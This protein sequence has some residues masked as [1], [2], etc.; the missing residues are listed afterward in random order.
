MKQSTSISTILALSIIIINVAI[1]PVHALAIKKDVFSPKDSKNEFLLNYG[2]NR[3]LDGVGVDF[4]N[5]KTLSI[6]NINKRNLSG[7][8]KKLGTDLL[9]LI[10]NDF[11]LVNQNR[12]QV[13]SQMKELK[14]FIAKE[15]SVKIL[16]RKIAD[17]K[18]NDLVYVYIKLKQEFQTFTIDPIVWKVTDRDEKNHLAVALVE[19]D[20]LEALA[21]LNSVK[22][23][24]SVVQPIVNSGSVVTEGD[25][26]HQTD[27]VRSNYSQSGAGIKVGVISDGVDNIALSQSSG[28]LPLGVNVLN[29][30]V[31]GDEGTAMLEIIHDMVPDATLYFHTGFPNYV[32]FNDAVEALVAAG[33]NV[34]VDDL[35]FLDQPYF[36]DGEIASHV[37]LVLEG[38][39]NVV[40]VSS[41]GNAAQEHYQ[42][43]FNDNGSGWHDFSAGLNQILVA[44]VP[45]G[46]RVT[47]FLQWNDSFGSSGND[48]DLYLVNQGSGNYEI[49]DSS[50]FEQDGD[51]DPLEYINYTNTSGSTIIVGIYIKKYF[52]LDRTLEINFNNRGGVSISQTFVTAADS[53]FGHPAVPGVIAVGAIDASDPGND[54]IEDFSS[55]GPVTIIGDGQRA[56]PDVVGIDGVSVTGVGGFS[57]PFFGTSAAA[58]HIAAIAAQLW[59]QYPSANGNQIRDHLLNTA[60]DLGDSGFDTIFGYGRADA[61]LAFQAN[62]TITSFNFAGLTPNVTG[63]INESA[64]TVALTVPYG[65]NVTALVPTIVITGSSVSPASGATQN[66]TSPVIYTV[67]ATGGLIQTYT[68]TVTVAASSAKEITS[69]GFTT[70]SATGVINEETHT[71]AVNVPY[72]TNVNN[73]VPTIVI[74]GASISPASGVAQNFTNPVVY[75]VTAEDASTQNYTATVTISPEHH[76]ISGTVKYYDEVK[77]VP[78]ATVI[79]EDDQSNQIATTATNESGYYEFTEPENG[80]NYVVSVE[81]SDNA[82][83]L[84]GGDQI[85]IGRHI[86]G[87]EL[88]STI[89]KTI[90]GDVNNTGGLSGGDQIK[91]GRFIVGLDSNLPS[92]A[93]KF[94]SSDAILNTENYLTIGL[95]RE[96]NNLTE[97]M[98]NQDFIGIKMGDVNN[99]WSND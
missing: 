52:G 34:I 17:K 10:D 4:S 80:N 43:I 64:H 1:F 59:G 87:L 62:P 7:P 82:L 45:N 49:L 54:D 25:I 96:Y 89:Y 92:G 19:V 6:D 30:S 41:A 63:T 55:Q 28:D 79:L 42:G 47:S 53:I 48:Y 72:G 37:A 57:N 50:V 22:S 93:W 67:T 74:T 15:N 76:T 16:N 84:S 36:E 21:S 68:V 70:P 58:P 12:A 51:D 13:V 27:D 75:T 14:Q 5:I 71:V 88:F 29:N 23:I 97:N 61:L 20:K 99:S 66:F 33:C 56:K 94:Y 40:H 8:K 95:N 90:A 85:K 86:V 26:I 46:D 65:T 81:K 2:Q 78:N 9:K 32:V 44:Y 39:D 18:H 60:V 35:G 83:G 77:L 69:F 73:L 11:L 91:I 31:G 98:A 24:R 38:N 3:L